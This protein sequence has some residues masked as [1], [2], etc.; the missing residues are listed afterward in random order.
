MTGEGKKETGSN[1]A[2]EKFAAEKETI[3]GPVAKKTCPGLKILGPEEQTA[4]SPRPRERQTRGGSRKRNGY[5]AGKI[6]F[7]LPAPKKHKA[8]TSI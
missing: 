7:R 4:A 1:M 2:I 8:R 5:L 6:K 3:Q